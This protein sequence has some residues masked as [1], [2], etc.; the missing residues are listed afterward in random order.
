MKYKIKAR[1]AEHKRKVKKESRKA[2]ANGVLMRQ[3][4]SKA[5]HLPNTDPDKAKIIKQRYFTEPVE[6]STNNI[7]KNTNNRTKTLEIPSL[8]N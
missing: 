1:S 5:I 7:K 4:R 3:E 2:A 8:M 6:K